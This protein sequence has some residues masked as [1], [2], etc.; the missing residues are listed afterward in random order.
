MCAFYIPLPTAGTTSALSDKEAYPTYSRVVAEDEQGGEAM[1]RLMD[2]FNFGE[3]CYLSIYALCK[4]G[5]FPLV[6]FVV[7]ECNYS[8][9]VC[10]VWC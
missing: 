8:R 4:H 1:A 10:D 2:Y 6:A 7:W 9:S 3:V 5:C